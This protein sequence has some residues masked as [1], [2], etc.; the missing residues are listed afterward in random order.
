M[1]LKTEGVS[2]E[3]ENGWVS[4]SYGTKVEAP[5]VKYSKTAEV[6]CEFVTVIAA[7]QIPSVGK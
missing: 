2:M 1:P 7:G 6:P 5:I 4:Y 3:I